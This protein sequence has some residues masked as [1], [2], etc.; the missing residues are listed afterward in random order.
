VQRG[1]QARFLLRDLN[2]LQAEAY[3]LT[4]LAES[5]TGLGHYPS[6]LSCLR[7]SLRL[8][9][10]IGDE[11]GEIGVLRDLVE[12]YEKLGNVERARACSE[13]A[14][15]KEEALVAFERRT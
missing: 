6:A 2:D 13:E 11:K 1:R 4:S 12:V 9:R 14:V 3:A 7:R 8:R 15:V 10:K 5:Y